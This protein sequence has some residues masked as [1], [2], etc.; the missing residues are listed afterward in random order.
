MLVL[1]NVTRQYRAGEVR[2]AAVRGV[3]LATT[4]GTMTAVMGPSGCGKST[5]LT[6]AG[7]LQ[8]A[9]SGTVT[10]AGV[11]IDQ[12]SENDLYRHRRRHIGYV[13][14]DYNLVQIL[15]V[16][17]NV[18][19]PAELDG[20]PRRKMRDRALG[21]LAMVG[22]ADYSDRYPDTLSGGQQQRVALARAICGDRRLILADEP[23][24]ALD[25]DN[26]AQVL[27]ALRTLVRAGATCVV[28]THDGSVAAQ[29][30]RVLHM[31]DG[32]LDGDLV[33]PSGARRADA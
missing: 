17:E 4:P 28:V 15:T 32:L 14:Q 10:V 26:A 31:R 7:G 25:S 18:M 27:D 24:G 16:L 21:A 11:R 22:M 33:E 12:L 2:V 6:I 5:L 8:P 30:D 9:D 1:E 19:L 20:L 29:A 23:T 3:S 13:F